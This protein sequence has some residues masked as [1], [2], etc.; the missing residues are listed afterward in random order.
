MIVKVGKGRQEI[1]MYYELSGQGKRKV[2]FIM[3]FTSTCCQWKN[4][5]RMLNERGGYECCIFD[6]R[7]VGHSGQPRG[8]YTTKLMARDTYEL[9]Q[10]LG[11]TEDICIVACSMGGFIAQEL[12]LLAPKHTFKAIIMT[13]TASS[14]PMSI[15]PI[16]TLLK[17]MIHK[18]GTKGVD[19]RI[20]AEVAASLLIPPAW[21]AQPVEPH[22]KTASPDAMTNVE[23][24]VQMLMYE[25]ATKPP[26]SQAGYRGQFNAVFFHNVS[27]KR[28][29]KLGT[30]SHF[31]VMAGSVDRILWPRNAAIIARHMKC[32]RILFEGKG[33]ALHH[34]LGDEFID[35][36]TSHFDSAFSELSEDKVQM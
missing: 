1:D 27:P 24:I 22:L 14:P 29:R 18:K 4:T 35:I 17:L 34:E 26:Q 16:T 36:V 33:H 3:G 25:A 28:L 9:L 7:G 20:R 31:L 21:G 19:A 23:A 8:L 13:S 6:N 30:L 11:W 5:V 12:C 15:P 2:L 10:H 32:K